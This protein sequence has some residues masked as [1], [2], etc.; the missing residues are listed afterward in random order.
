MPNCRMDVFALGL[1]FQ[2]ML[3][4]DP[5]VSAG[6]AYAQMYRILNEAPVPPST[7]NPRIDARIDAIV[8]KAMQRS[9]CERYADNLAD[10]HAEIERR[11]GLNHVDAASA[12][13]AVRGLTFAGLGTEVARHW[14]FPDSI[15]AAVRELPQGS[16]AAVEV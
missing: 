7:R 14:N 8:P 1:V 16:A 4:A 13:R 2:E 11:I 5:V 9:P 15:T 10:E 6:N 12:A 3:T